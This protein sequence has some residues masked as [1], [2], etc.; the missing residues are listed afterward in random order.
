MQTRTS[1]KTRTAAFLIVSAATLLI[2]GAASAFDFSLVATYYDTDPDET[3]GAG[4]RL[5]FGGRT[6]F[7][8]GASYV[9]QITDDR[10]DFSTDFIPIDAGVRFPPGD[11]PLFFGVG[12]TYYLIDSDRFNVDDEFGF[13]ARAGVEFKIGFFFDVEF[14]EVEGSVE[15]TDFDF[16]GA[17]RPDLDLSGWAVN[18]GWAF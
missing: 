6:Q 3:Y 12:G 13:Y 2:P 8:V 10:F 14:R 7:E 16:G 11:G 15:G 17:V 4:I 18:V 5:G 9:D 1:P